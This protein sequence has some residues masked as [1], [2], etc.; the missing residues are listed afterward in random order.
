MGAVVE[1]ALHA[2]S[3]RGKLIAPELLAKISVFVTH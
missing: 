1:I 3:I 2:T